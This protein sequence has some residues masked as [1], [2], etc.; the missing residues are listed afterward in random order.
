MRNVFCWG[1]GV[2]ASARSILLP[3]A[4]RQA[5]T[6]GGRR[7]QDMGLLQPP[8]PPLAP[9][10][11]ALSQGISLAVH[12]YRVFVSPAAGLEKLLP[13]IHTFLVCPE[14]IALAKDVDW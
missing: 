5:L 10:L 8:A 7:G 12:P 2:A 3:M 11:L 14:N 6:A 9:V 1:L 4:Q 13:P